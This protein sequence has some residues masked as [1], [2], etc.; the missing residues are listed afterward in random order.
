MSSPQ[1]V[2]EQAIAPSRSRLRESLEGFGSALPAAIL[3]AILI[4]V[5]VVQAFK[6]PSGS[7]L[8]TLQIGDHIL[9][10]KFLY[11]ARVEIPFTQISLGKLPGVRKPHTG[12][13]VVFIY[14]RNRDQDFIK[15]VVASEGQTVEM[16]NQQIYIDGKRWD[17]PHG[18]FTYGQGGCSPYCADYGPYTVPAGHIF[19]MGDNRNQSYDS[20]FWGSVPMED[21]KGMAMITYWSWNDQT[22]TDK[23]WVRW[24]RLG[25]LVY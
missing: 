12:D 8:P 6:I 25:R 9:V 10:N 2:D 23:R 4:R 20:R 7:M 1:P 22:P 11:G 15:R 18:N 17:D 16:R 19:C 3:L 14:P 13:V 5:F 21:V 24:E